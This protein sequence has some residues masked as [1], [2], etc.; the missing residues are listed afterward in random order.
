MNNKGATDEVFKLL[1]AIIVIAAV[2]GIM[3]VFLSNVEEAGGNSINATT[4]ALEDFSAKIANRTA[5][6]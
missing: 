5:S 1:L 6:F 3:A 2:L 4:N